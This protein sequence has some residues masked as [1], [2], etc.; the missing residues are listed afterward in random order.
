[1]ASFFPPPLCIFW[2]SVLH[3]TIKQNHLAQLQEINT[4]RKAANKLLYIQTLY[5]NPSFTVQSNQYLEPIT[6]AE[7]MLIKFNSAF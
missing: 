7:Q 2:T 3:C 1:M 5:C 6:L 4:G